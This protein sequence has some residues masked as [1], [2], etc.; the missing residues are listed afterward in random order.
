[1]CPYLGEYPR[2][3]TR[4]D[5]APL[6]PQGPRLRELAPQP[7]RP[8]ALDGGHR[9]GE[10]AAEPL[11]R[12]LHPDGHRHRRLQAGRPGRGA[13]AARSAA[14]PAGSSSSP[15]RTSTSA[16]RACTC[17]QR[18][19]AGS[20]IR[21]CSSSQETAPSRAGSRR[22]TSA[23]CSTRRSSPTP[24]APPTCSRCRR[25]PTCSRRPRRRAS[26][27]ARRASSFDRGGVIDVV[28]H[29]ET[30]YQ[31]KFGDVDDLARGLTTLLG[32][33]ELL[34][35]LSRRCREVA[36]T[37]F[38]VQQQVRAVRRALRGARRWPARSLASSSRRTSRAGSSSRRCAPCSSR[39]TS[40]SR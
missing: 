6:P 25:S 31:A 27:A 38:A 28:R 5:G 3:R 19:C 12:A 15:R 33:S 24:T 14:R 23:R 9:R 32:D 10:P 20:T 18:R 8:V 26:R 35:R 16:G 29:L 36:E 34:E 30:G 4:Q 40:R 39:S 21:R 1:M 22:A 2:L 11:P 37:E 13:Q 17:S 7:R